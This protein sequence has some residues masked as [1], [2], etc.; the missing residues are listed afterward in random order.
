M[1]IIINELN[2]HAH[3]RTKF[4]FIV[5]VVLGMNGVLDFE[6]NKYIYMYM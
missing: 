6:N 4:A 1:I 3:F 5:V 2:M